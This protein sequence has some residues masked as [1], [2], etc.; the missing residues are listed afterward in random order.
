M[1]EELLKLIDEHSGEFE[2]VSDAVWGFAETCFNEHKSSALQMQFMADRGFR[3]TTPVCG[4]DT[5]FIAECGSGAPILAIL[6]ENDALPNMSQ[7][8]GSD[9]EEPIVAGENG[10]GCGHHLLG[11]G[12]MEAAAALKIYM[13]KNGLPGTI[14][15]YACP[16]EEGGGGKVYMAC[17][18]AFDDVDAAVTWHPADQNHLCFAGKSCVTANFQ[19]FG[20]AAHAAGEPWN[21]RSALDAVELMNVS[22]QF[23]R[24]HMKTDCRLH[25]AILNSGGTAPNVVHKEAMVQYVVRSMD[26]AYLN[27]LFGRVCDIAK[28]AALM[29][30]TTVSEP[31]IISAYSSRI[32]NYTF[33]DVMLEN[34]K[35]LLPIQ[36][37]EEEL[38]CA[39]KYNAL[40][41]HPDPDAPIATELDDR[42]RTE[43][44]GT[45]D[46]N[47]AS[48]FVPVMQADVALCPKGVPGHSW[49]LVS[50]GKTPL[51]HKG[52]HTAAKIM[53]TTLL[54]LLESPELVEKI[55]DEFHEN[56]KGRK[57]K[58]LMPCTDFTKRSV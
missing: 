9:K 44:G 45:T 53:A 38:A 58:S 56:M 51:A 20:K 50:M 55:K 43:V 33:A 22:A 36:Y 18:G 5:A 12:G 3:I 39:K 34:W 57:Y 27:E 24:E 46:V 48:W 28:G 54:D 21:G 47:D 1:K 35:A 6:G 25:Y 2:D 52:M 40:G 26:G 41:V 15:Y 4:M 16:A 32:F 11:T 10:H 23:L 37:T 13:E 30:G 49:Q 14:R 19:F 42:K 31:N 17:G 7:V 29:T 8:A